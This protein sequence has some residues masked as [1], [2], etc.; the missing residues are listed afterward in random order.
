MIDQAIKISEHIQQ[1]S[2]LLDETIKEQSEVK[3]I[4]N[5]LALSIIIATSL[6]FGAAAIAW[7]AINTG[8]IAIAVIIALICFAYTCC[9]KSLFIEFKTVRL[10]AAGLTRKRNGY[11]KRL[12]ELLSAD[13]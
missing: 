3:T 4:K 1:L 9:I 8:Q 7:H 12:Q 2:N 10:V 13:M 5:A 6:L 11:L